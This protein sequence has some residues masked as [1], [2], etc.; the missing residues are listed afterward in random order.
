MFENIILSRRSIRKFKENKI[1]QNIVEELACAAYFSP[2]SRGKRAYSIIFIEDKTMLQKLAQA[3]DGSALLAGAALGVIIAGHPDES[4]VW[5]ED[6][7]IASTNILNMCQELTLGA[8]WVQI[9]N[10]MHSPDQS[11]DSYVKQLVVIPD[12]YSVECIIGI[13]YPDEKKPAYNKKDL[14]KNCFYQGSYGSPLK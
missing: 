9:R 13:G 12:N 4:D 6:C 5:I 2:S 7:S 3:K 8:C 1:E 11:A 14:D 10:R